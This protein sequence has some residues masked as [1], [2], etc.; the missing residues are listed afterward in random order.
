MSR[1]TA[2]P[3]GSSKQIPSRS[4]PTRNK[5]KKVIGGA[6]DEEIA[7]HAARPRMPRPAAVRQLQR[8]RAKGKNGKMRVGSKH[9]N[10]AAEALLGMGS[11][12]IDD[13]TMVRCSATAP[14]VYEII[15]VVGTSDSRVGW[16]TLDLS[17]CSSS[18]PPCHE[19]LHCSSTTG[20]H[21]TCSDVCVLWL[22]GDVPMGPLV[23][24]MSHPETLMVMQ[25]PLGTDMYRG[26]CKRRMLP[27]NRLP[28]C[29]MFC[30]RCGSN[31]PVDACTEYVRAPQVTEFVW[32]RWMM[33]ERRWA[34]KGNWGSLLAPS[35][36]AGWYGPRW[37]AMS[38]GL[39]RS[40]VS[41]C[42]QILLHGPL[43]AH[44]QLCAWHMSAL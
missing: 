15:A 26:P 7:E 37:M 34:M 5:T 10:E 22:S 42:Q 4:R 29:S 13:D 2:Q 18:L 43:N 44:C 20:L 27:A 35:G 12:F 38:G 31:A 39:P 33:M 30:T 11:G 28:A 6:T 16:L 21:C 36:Q 24:M 32:H 3:E 25:L 23:Y 17:A 8:N 41:A 19:S 1:R 40:A 14:H 9:I